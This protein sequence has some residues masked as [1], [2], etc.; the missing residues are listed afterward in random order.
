MIIY[1][2]IGL[3]LSP[4]QGDTSMVDIGAVID[5]EFMPGFVQLVPPVVVL[6]LVL[7]RQPA[8]PSLLL[9]VVLGGVVAMLTQD[10]SLATVL[11]AAMTGHVSRTGHAAVDELLSRGGMLSMASTVFLI[12]TAMT[13]GGIMER[14]G[15]LATLAERVLGLARSTAGL[16]VT[17]VLTCMGMNVVAADQY[18]AIVV[19]GRMY[20]DAFRKRGLHPKNLSRA[21]EDAGTITSPLV[22]W[23]TCGAF[24]S[25]T[26]MVGTF[27]Y[28]PYAFLNLLNPLISMFYGVTGITM[29]PLDPDDG[30]D[31]GA[32]TTA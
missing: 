18:I 21:L 5:R 9:G 1:T 22:P 24:M 2:A 29:T 19:P 12:L 3:G 28:L 11:D 26:L 4:A 31:T 30:H 27:A 6:G 16:V 23:N 15:M 10:A 20:A 32:T 8:L 17:T 14:T 13:F 7:A 25:A